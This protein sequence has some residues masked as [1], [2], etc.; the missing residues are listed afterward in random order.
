MVSPQSTG[1]YKLGVAEAY[2]LILHGRTDEVEVVREILGSNW[3]EIEVKLKT[4][5][6]HRSAMILLPTLE[7]KMLV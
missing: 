2:E 4:V 6:L 5:V 3:T 7:M 1:L